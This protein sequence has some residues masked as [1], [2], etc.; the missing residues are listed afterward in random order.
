MNF[1]ALFTSV[2]RNLPFLH[3][4]QRAAFAPCPSEEAVY[5]IAARMGVVLPGATR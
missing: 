1:A 4:G 5:R 2:R 3:A